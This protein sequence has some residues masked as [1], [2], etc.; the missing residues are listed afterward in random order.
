MILLWYA[1][2]KGQLPAS[3]GCVPGQEG[4]TNFVWIEEATERGVRTLKNSE[5]AVTTNCRSHT[6][7]F[8][9]GPAQT[10]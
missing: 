6:H 4:A 1:I 8:S 2:D 3:S 10:F 5:V 7:F 9:E